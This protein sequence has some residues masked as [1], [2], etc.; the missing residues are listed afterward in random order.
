MKRQHSKI[1]INKIL[2]FIVV[3]LMIMPISVKIFNISL[4]KVTA[5]IIIF[6]FG[7]LWKKKG[8]EEIKK[9][10]NNKFVI[11]NFVFSIII[12]VS[13]LVNYRT[14]QV[15]DFYEVLKYILFPVVTMIVM[16]ICKEQKYYMFFLKTIS[17]VMIIISIWGIIQ[18]YNPFS[19]NELYIRSYAPTQYETL[20][21]GYDSPRIVG[22]K[23]NP[24]VWG[25]LVSIGVYFNFL[26]YKYSK[27]KFWCIISTILCI[28]N[29][30]MTLTRTIQIAF[31]VSI[32]LY[33]LIKSLL[34]Q[35]WKK[36]ILMLLATIGIMGIIICILPKNI[37]WRLMQVFDLTNTTSWIG[38]T[39]KW[40]NYGDI[41]KTQPIFGV[42]PVKNYVKEL[43]YID[44]EL[45]QNLLQYGL[46]GFIIYLVMLISPIYIY[47]KDKSKKHILE[48]YVPILVMILVNNIAAASLI[49]FDTA[50]S[51]YA[52]IGVIMLKENFETRK[53]E[54][55]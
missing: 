8:T 54:E 18:Y 34:K 30:M 25:L 32:M 19:I 31:I 50:I 16:L 37:T 48:Y 6:I 26:Y 39:E 17:I 38:R 24:A 43:G 52:I 49:L 35:G 51:I 5:V 53:E 36:A 10:V 28:V 47:I 13:L 46:S 15:N 3:L 11:L 21:N 2:L 55:T 7:Y 27:N 41:I 22:I 9:V 44:S 33:I 12:A 29:L 20:V 14:I 42:G 1:D 4:V 45:I 40:E 23:T